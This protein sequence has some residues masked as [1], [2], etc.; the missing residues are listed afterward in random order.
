MHGY[1]GGNSD[2]MATLTDPTA[3]EGEDRR[4]ER[5][6]DT[7]LTAGEG[8]DR[9]RERAPDTL[10]T[11]GEGEDRRRERAPDTG[12]NGEQ[13]ALL[14]A[15]LSGLKKAVV[16]RQNEMEKMISRRTRERQHSFLRQGNQSQYDFTDTVRGQVQ[17]ALSD[18]ER[19]GSEETAI[20]SLR[21]AVEMLERRMRLIKMADRSE[22]GW[23]VVAEYEADELAVDSDDEKRIYRAEKEAE[24]KW[25]K[26]RKRQDDQVDGARGGTG[27][28]QPRA[29]ANIG[30]SLRAGPCF[31]CGEWGH[32]KR[33]CPRSV[34]GAMPPT[35]PSAPVHIPPTSHAIV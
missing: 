2:K 30:A 27:A 15:E 21:K 31:G 17:D 10:P 23:A 8:E 22:Y 20:F 13:I 26:K 3:G 16:K 19:G 5:A 34:R 25:L 29:T 12:R 6:P 32:L 9:R 18:L 28:T 1:C 24:K 14:L 4:R 7:D 33:N 11:A 35:I